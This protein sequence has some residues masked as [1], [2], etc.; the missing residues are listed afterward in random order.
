M[1]TMKHV[2]GI[3]V[4]VETEVVETFWNV[5]GIATFPEVPVVIVVLAVAGDTRRIHSVAKRIVTVAVATDQR[6]VLAD[7]REGCI[8]SMV[9]RG[10][11]P[12]GRLVAV[13]ALL[14]AAAVMRIVLSMTAETGCRYFSKGVFNMT[15]ETP[16][17]CVVTN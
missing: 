11:M 7:Q 9:E 10:V 4:V 5:T 15:V 17:C 16:G 14:A 8:A 12:V 13:A 6:S 3:D 2:V 1:R